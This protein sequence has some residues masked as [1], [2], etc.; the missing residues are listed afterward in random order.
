MTEQIRA[1]DHV[2]KDQLRL[3]VEWKLSGQAGRVGVNQDRFADIADEVI[4]KISNAAFSTGD[5]ELQIKILSAIPGIGNATAAVILT[6][7]DPD[8]YVVGGRSVTEAVLGRRESVTP[9][10]YPELLQRLR[11]VKPNGY[12]LRDLERVFVIRKSE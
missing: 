12:P 3:I 6:F 9:T 11:E 1:Q 4:R 2:T 8:H 7:H 10:N 5:P